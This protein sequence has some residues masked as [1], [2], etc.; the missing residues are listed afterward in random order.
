MFFTPTTPLT[1]RSP[2]GQTHPAAKWGS[3]HRGW[4]C[5]GSRDLCPGETGVIEPHPIPAGILLAD[6]EPALS[7]AVG[8]KGLSRHPG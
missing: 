5:G 2:R 4:S 3:W 8:L 6:Q 7:G 1:L